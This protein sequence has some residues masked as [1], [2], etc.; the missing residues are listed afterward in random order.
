MKLFLKYDFNMMGKAILDEQLNKIKLPFSLLGPGEVEILK[1]LSDTEEELLHAQLKK[2]GIEIV[3][4][5]KRILVQKIKDAIIEMIYVQ[6]NLPA[7]K[8]SAYLASKLQHSYGHLAKLFS[9]VT[10]TSIENYIILQKIEYA[11][12]LILT[13]DLTF[14]EI[15]LKLNYSSV[16]HFSTQF[17]NATGLTPSAFKLIISK[18]HHKENR[19][20]ER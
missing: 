18:R 15:S 6:E 19:S 3:E 12:Q 11:K 5:P 7:S 1:T 17:K 2:Y 10:Y 8:I 20:K 13:N 16:A 14:T 9:E 4:T